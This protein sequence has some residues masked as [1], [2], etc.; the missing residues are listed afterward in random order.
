MNE[1]AGVKLARAEQLSARQ[2]IPAQD[3]DTARSDAK[4]AGGERP[5]RRHSYSRL[6]P[7]S[8]KHA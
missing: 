2:L 1:D 8:S 5:R 4:V 7:P 6:A 3:V